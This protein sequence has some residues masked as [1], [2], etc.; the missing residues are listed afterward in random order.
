[1]RSG[2]ILSVAVCLA[3]L[4]IAA[5]GQTGDNVLVVA[6]ETVPASIEIGEYYAKRRSIPAMQLLK[7]RTSSADQLTRLEFERTIHGP[8][9]AWL[10]RNQAQDRILYIV[11]TKG[12]PLR[13]AGT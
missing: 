9:G 3:L 8:I 6:N 2:R 12:I 5:F 10:S 11:L 1:M 13:I 4:P 7:I